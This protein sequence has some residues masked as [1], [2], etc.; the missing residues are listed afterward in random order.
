MMNRDYK[1]LELAAA[2]V[3]HIL[4]LP[5]RQVVLHVRKC[6]ESV[7]K[8]RRN[9]SYD[10]FLNL[11]LSGLDLYSVSDVQK[12]MFANLVTRFRSAIEEGSAVEEVPR[13]ELRVPCN[14]M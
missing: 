2:D 7:A 12:E 5:P 9:A 8:Y 10:A 3:D 4:K 1:R 14:M 13:L 6:W 11:R